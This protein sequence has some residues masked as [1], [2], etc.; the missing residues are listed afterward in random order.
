MNRGAVLCLAAFLAGCG[1]EQSP[2]A[3]PAWFSDRAAE[4]GAAFTLSTTLSGAPHLPEIVAGGAAALDFDNDG[5]IDLYLVQAAGGGNVLLHNNGDGTFSD[6]S[7]A[8]GADD[9]GYGMG[10]ATG[11]VD[12]DGDVDLYVT[13]VGENVLL[14]NNGDGTFTDAT[15]E[16]GVGHSGF[17]ASASFFDADNDG[18]LDLFL[19]NYV[20]WSPEREL[21][22]RTRAGE[23]DYCAP[24]HYQAP[25][26]DVVY[27][28][29][30]DGT[31]TNVTVDAGLAGALGN[32]LGVVA[33]DFT[34]DG[35]L[36]LFVA[37]DG[38]PDRLW[39]NDGSGRFEDQAMV[40]GCDRDLT[41][42]AKAG[43]GVV[44]EDFEGDDDVD[45]IVCNLVGE[46]DSLY[47]NR[48]GR[49]VDAAGRA[50]LASA[51][52]RHTRFGVGLVDFDNDGVRD[53]YEANGRVGTRDPL[54]AKDPYAEPNL[55]LRGMPDGTFAE[56][57]S[58][59]DSTPRTSR[60]AVFADFDNDGGLDTLVI[61]R[62]APAR[63]LMNVVPER[64]HWVMLD[65][66][67]AFG[68]PAIGAELTATLGERTIRRGVHTDGSYL[69]A[70][71]PRIHVGLGTATTLEDV[72]VT[73]P[74]GSTKNLGTIDADRIHAVRP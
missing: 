72:T 34:G 19:A 3:T 70:H 69:A 57:V 37:N 11:D 12:H 52:R 9:A 48:D 40:R 68:A 5:W 17:G 18:D 36:D 35:H 45:L 22:C 33:R 47:E 14:L 28:N 55:L 60:A 32:G 44:G 10:V 20:D 62:N 13:N 53:L 74:D 61:N 31:F 50:G 71:D 43:M 15:H 42:K 66:K 29:N 4:S 26:E 38:N 24:V 65:V 49:F 67:D 41:G 51:S 59:G 2:I 63:L 54:Y 23:L 1:E 21:E 27:R 39:V 25:S 58:G 8:S 46:A 30:S 64:G 7:A 56:R 6:V 73:W 16:A